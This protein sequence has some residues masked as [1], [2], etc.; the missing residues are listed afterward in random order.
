[1]L[2]K[3]KVMVISGIGPGLGV[4]LAVEAAREGAAAVVI[5]ARTA[6]KLDDAENRIRKTGSACAVL[7]CV[8]D[9]TDRAQCQALADAAVKQFGRIDALVNSAF[10]HGAMDYASTADVDAWQGRSAPT[11]SA[12]SNSRRR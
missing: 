9:I 10:L 7:K 1:M 6:L 8:T 3:N 4:K 5:A 11:C 12:H 2:L